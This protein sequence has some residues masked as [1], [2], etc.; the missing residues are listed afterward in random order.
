MRVITAAL[1]FLLAV[2]GTSFAQS[3]P[4]D[5]PLIKQ[6]FPG[7]PPGVHTL[8]VRIA[9]LGDREV[10]FPILFDTGSAGMTIQ[11]DIVL[12]ADLCGTDGILVQRDMDI[13]GVLV[14]TRRIVSQYG[15]YDEYGNLAFA[16]VT[17][18]DERGSVTTQR[19]PFLLRYK[20]VRRSTGEVV[21]GP[22]WTKGIFGVAPVAGQVDGLLA[23][24]MD[25]V[26]MPT[27]LGRGFWLSPLGE[28]WSVC[29]NERG[30]C[31]T[32]DA[33]HIGLDDGARSQFTM[34]PLRSSGSAHYQPFVDACLTWLEYQSCAP[35]LYDTGNSTVAIAG[36]PRSGPA[37]TLPPGTEVTLVG[38]EM[39]LW[40][41]KARDAIEVEFAP[42]S[43][44]NLIGIRYFETNS[45]LFDL[46]ARQIGFRIGR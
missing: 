41:F 31:P 2:P 37:P 3:L 27:G 35:A 23:S 14:T 15:T 17:F 36:Q 11:C 32:V 18:G 8:Y 16:R 29:T 44:V 24:P 28:S 38:P 10:D 12:P 21:G 5:V 19:M 22:L 7:R 4:R 30:D 20:K 43:D 9:A 34:V 46:D 1:L 42:Y 40:Q 13:G 39:T 33:L 45:L 25:Y 6:E 26:D